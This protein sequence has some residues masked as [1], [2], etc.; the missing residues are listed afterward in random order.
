[1][2][3]SAPLKPLR[4]E[5][6]TLATLDLVHEL[7]AMLE[8]SL[9]PDYLAFLREHGG[10]L[11][12]DRLHHVAAP[13]LVPCPLGKFAEVEVMYGFYSD[14]SEIYDLRDVVRTYRGAIPSNFAAIGNDIGENQIVLSCI[15]P[16]QGSV[17]LWDREFSYLN[18][19]ENNLQIFQELEADGVSTQ[20]LNLH[21]A[22]MIW[23]SRHSA[24]LGRPP[25]YGPL[26]LLAASFPAFLEALKPVPY[27]QAEDQ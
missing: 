20:S 26:Y 15:G 27:E 8:L 1:M 12:G 14:P 3:I 25:G 21:E 17:Y 9:P 4:F 10:S 7:E 11:M 13:I 5:Q 2:K 19:L 24:A 22:V 16:D 18:D 6:R 23:E